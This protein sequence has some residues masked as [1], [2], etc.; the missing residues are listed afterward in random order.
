MVNS[1]KIK[2]FWEWISN[3]SHEISDNFDNTILLGQLDEWI[4][5]LRNFNWEIGP[6]KNGQ[7]AIKLNANIVINPNYSDCD[8]NG[9]KKVHKATKK[10]DQ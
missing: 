1:D 5:R 7:T 3:H 10:V 2:K 9:K 6:E 8:A 4:N